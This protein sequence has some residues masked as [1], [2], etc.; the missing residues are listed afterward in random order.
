MKTLAC[1]LFVIVF[2]II[3]VNQNQIFAQ[4][5]Y[6]PEWLKTNAKW[7]TM[8]EISNDEYR[9]DLDWLIDNGLVEE[10]KK[11]KEVK[12]PSQVISA[13][14]TLDD[15]TIIDLRKLI[16]DLESRIEFLEEQL[17]IAYEQGITG[18]RGFQG[19]K[20][21]IGDKGEMG[22]AGPAGE[23]GPKGP[24]GNPGPGLEV[25]KSSCERTSTLSKTR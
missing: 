10:T 3:F 5:N 23:K 22:Q 20:G 1:L 18:P 7:W 8:G 17:V 21:T 19:A 6:L 9:Q 13:T 12:I 24:Q 14:P 2:S 25:I 15:K 4:E 11:Q 16:K